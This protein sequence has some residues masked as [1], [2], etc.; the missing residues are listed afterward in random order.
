M[1]I[2]TASTKILAAA[3]TRAALLFP[4]AIAAGSILAA[5]A[6]G[7]GLIY[8]IGHQMGGIYARQLNPPYQLSSDIDSSVSPFE[9]FWNHVKVKNQRRCIPRVSAKVLC[10]LVLLL[11]G[12]FNGVSI[13][14]LPNIKQMLLFTCWYGSMGLLDEFD[15]LEGD[16][17]TSAS[18][19]FKKFSQVGLVLPIPFLMVMNP[20]LYVSFALC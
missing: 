12:Q 15:D 14:A 13:A 16:M 4:P 10:A 9:K 5:D 6:I 19:K 20:P 2:A 11:S 8:M 3:T 7:C 1:L 17:K 18:R